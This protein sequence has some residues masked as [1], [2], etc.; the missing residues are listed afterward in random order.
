MKEA[1]RKQDAMHDLMRLIILKDLVD[2]EQFTVFVFPMK[3]RF[4]ST[5][6]S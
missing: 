6:E 2:H 3:K 1:K 4:G 5:Q